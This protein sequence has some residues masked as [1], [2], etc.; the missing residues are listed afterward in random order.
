MLTIAFGYM[1]GSDI[2]FF[3]VHILI[4]LLSSLSSILC[5]VI[6]MF[7]LIST[8][9]AVKNAAIDKLVE[10]EDYYRTRKFKKV[11]FPWIM[12]SIAS[13]LAAPILGAGY[14][15]GKSPLWLHNAAVWELL[16][17]FGLAVYLSQN[18]LSQNKKILSTTIK[19]VNADVDRRLAEKKEKD[20]AGVDDIM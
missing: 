5:L 15:T 13:L 19:A 11:L 16:F 12:L 9:V 3:Q 20:E 18:V 17:V 7:Y 2:A 4:G 1:G 14:D 8:G 10:A 6:V